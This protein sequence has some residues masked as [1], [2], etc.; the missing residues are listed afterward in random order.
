MER[1]RSIRL[2]NRIVLLCL[3][4]WLA[5]G[6]TSARAFC[7]DEFAR[8][9]VLVTDPRS[10]FLETLRREI[11]DANVSSVTLVE[12]AHE[13]V[14]KIG[15]VQNDDRDLMKL[16]SLIEMTPKKSTMKFTRKFS[17]KELIEAQIEEAELGVV[18][19]VTTSGA[20]DPLYWGAR[21]IKDFQTSFDKLKV[22]EACLRI[23]GTVELSQ[24][25]P[26]SFT[27]LPGT[28]EYHF[29]KP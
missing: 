18:N 23:Y 16:I 10:Q 3:A 13:T 12:R 9:Q 25:G 6:S 19:R 5:V 8:L 24:C 14:L 7:G 28:S 11:A 2:Q 29:E 15:Y 21:E 26:L 1:R 17:P 20:P 22:R 4:A 27:I